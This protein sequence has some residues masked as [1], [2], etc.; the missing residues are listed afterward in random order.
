MIAHYYCFMVD[1]LDK[2]VLCNIMVKL[3]LLTEKDLVHYAKMCS[4]YHKNAFL[5]D[6]LLTKDK[7]SI[8]E[9]CQ[10]LQNTKYQQ[11]LGH[12]L[13]HGKSEV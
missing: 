9:F 8:T 13:E 12:M 2:T 11:E 4:E 5:L 7:S 6:Q 1:T 3:K 10:M